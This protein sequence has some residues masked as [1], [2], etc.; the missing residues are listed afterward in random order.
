M[1]M[2]LF[3]DGFKVPQLHPRPPNFSPTTP[4][5]RFGGFGYTCSLSR[6]VAGTHEIFK[7]GEIDAKSEEVKGGEGML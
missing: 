2:V 5:P 7:D 3:G 4:H 6:Q 1:V